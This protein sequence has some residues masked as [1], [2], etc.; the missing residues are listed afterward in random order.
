MLLEAYDCGLDTFIA[1]DL[2]PEAIVRLR[3]TI[4]R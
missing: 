3:Q 1:S 4:R 2:P